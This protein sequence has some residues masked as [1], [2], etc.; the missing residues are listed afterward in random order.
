[1]IGT[2]F[3]VLIRLELAAPGVQFLAGDHQLFNVII[4]AHALIMIFFMVMP[5]LVGGFG[6]YNYFFFNNFRRWYSISKS[7]NLSAPHNS[8][9]LVVSAAGIKDSYETP[10]VLKESKGNINI[11]NFKKTQLGPYLAGLIEGDGTFAIHDKDS[12][13]KKYNPV[14][15]IVFKKA[16][17]PLAN[18]LQK[19]TNS[20]RVY[21]KPERG[22]VLWQIQDLVS[23]FT[24]LSLI[25]GYM[26]TPKIEALHREIIWLNNYI[27]TNKNQSN[28]QAQK[29]TILE[30]I[31]TLEC[32]PLDT[33]PIDS[34]SWFAGF[35]DADSNF[36]IN[37]HKRSN[38]NTTR[39]QLNYSLEIKQ[40]YH[41]TVADAAEGTKASFFPIMSKI[42]LYLGVTVYSRSRLL[43]DKIFYSFTVMS[44]NKN[45][46]SKLIAYFEK[47]PLLSSKFLD[48][49]DWA[50]ILELQ[51]S[52]KLTTS[53]LDKAVT[54]RTDFNSTRSTFKWGH[55]NSCY[56]TIT[57]PS[58]GDID[59][60]PPTN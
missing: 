7:L 13:V 16:D 54:I 43:N 20:G 36:S 17:L 32:K 38:R 45:S 30:K 27:E 11:N 4:S 42:G 55:L 50:Y 56:L 9:G 49:K 12:M 8:W 57:E 44:H 22:Y 1:M 59:V 6:K 53:Y 33:S 10:Q 35:S 24:I 47:F 25:N 34:N 52:N 26:R 60:S 19:L 39:V 28:V 46:H 31:H 51:R 58:F 14:I 40:N 5:G 2:A 23:I 21:I 18:Y 15:I 37:I 3:S 29:V 48:Y 41:R